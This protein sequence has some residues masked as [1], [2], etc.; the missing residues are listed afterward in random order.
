[1]KWTIPENNEKRIEMEIMRSKQWY[2]VYCEMMG[3][4]FLGNKSDY[5]ACDKKEPIKLRD[6]TEAGMGN[7]QARKKKERFFW[8]QE[9]PPTIVDVRQ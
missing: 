9:L 7:R 4:Y 5:V 8:N 3:A 2:T 6:V 1:L